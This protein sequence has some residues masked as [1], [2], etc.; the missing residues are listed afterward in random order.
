MKKLKFLS[1]Q[2]KGNILTHMTTLKKTSLPINRLRRYVE[3]LLALHGEFSRRFEDFAMLRNETSVV[4]FSFSCCVDDTPSGIQLELIDLQSDALLPD[5]FKSM[6]LLH[7]YFTL[8]EEKFANLWRHAQKMLVLFGSTYTCEQAS[9]VMKFNKSR[10]KFSLTED[11][12]PAIL[13]ISTF[14]IQP[15]FG[16][17]SFQKS[18]I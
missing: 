18:K 6:P 1:S 14:D 2:L 16:A 12:L 7:F 13:F 3:M 8:H 5:H 11:H 4:F 10:H 17:I 15:D 9:S